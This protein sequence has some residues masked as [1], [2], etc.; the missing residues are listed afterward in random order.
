MFSWQKI[1]TIIFFWSRA[2][3]GLGTWLI[4]SNVVG[5]A[6]GAVNTLNICGPFYCNFAVLETGCWKFAYC[7]TLKQQF[8]E[9]IELKH[10]SSNW[11][12]SVK[13]SGYSNGRFRYATSNSIT[14]DTRI[15]FISYWRVYTSVPVKLQ[16]VV[17]I[18]YCTYLPGL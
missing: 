18:W 1:A 2:G 5:G 15:K 14:D 10:E 4:I 12:S 9:T 8:G 11:N 17:Y 7:Y 16:S 13:S 6:V 3:P